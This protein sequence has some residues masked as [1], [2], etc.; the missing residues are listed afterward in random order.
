MIQ[1]ITVL[2][3]LGGAFGAILA[4][5]SKK[6]A[7]E[8]DPRVDAIVE[9]LPGANCGA[10]GYPGCAGLANAIVNDGAP[11]NA[12]V[13]GKD[14][15]AAEIAKIMG[16]EPVAGSIRQVVQL[17]CNGTH[18]NAKKVYEYVGV[19]DCH[20][21]VTQFGGPSYCSYACI[22]LGSCERA[23]PFDAIHMNKDGLP[24][25]DTA[26]CTG[27]GLCSIQC[28]QKILELVP[29]NK[30]VY[31]RCNNRD[32]GKVAK[33]ACTVSCISCGICVKNCPEQAIT[34]ATGKTGAGSVAVIDYSKCTNCGTCVEKCP[35]KSI[36]LDP[37]IDPELVI[38]EQPQ[39]A[40]GCA[41][42]SAKGVCGLR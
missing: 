33:D 17:H 38:V 25:V 27:C 6:L 19:S 3:V 36:H 7:V 9:A 39:E 26:T 34:L 24:V 20:S 32:K 42:C 31:I 4:I 37:P 40:E 41:S 23:C 5:A 1:A 8:T 10:C 22:G 12:C 29:I 14:G 18:A 13:P 30:Q 28:P 35:R 15:V 21:A 16:M 2:A 11:I